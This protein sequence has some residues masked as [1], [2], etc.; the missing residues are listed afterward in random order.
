MLDF[1]D[2]TKAELVYFLRN[3]C[4]YNARDL[5]ENLL[6]TRLSLTQE[7]AE[8]ADMEA[9]QA[10]DDYLKVL[11]KAESLATLSPSA[12]MKLQKEGAQALKRM[13]AALKK[14]EKLSKKAEELRLQWKMF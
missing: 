4:V 13:E 3:Y 11:K 2:M 1:N 7:A 8:K 6:S 5:D 10:M 14:A 12:R 9:G